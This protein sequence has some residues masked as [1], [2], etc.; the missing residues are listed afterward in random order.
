[1]KSSYFD[2][3]IWSY[4]GL[5]LVNIIIAIVTL[6]LGTP[7]ILVRTYRWES[8]HTV[9]NGQR[10]RFNGDSVSL[11]GH[12]VIW[13]ILTLITFGLYG[14][15]VRVKLISWRVENTEMLGNYDY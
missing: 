8:E 6:G 10:F 4:I 15:I 13:W 5:Q 3:S 1:M 14:I 11:F 7:W 12:W 9:I 2:G